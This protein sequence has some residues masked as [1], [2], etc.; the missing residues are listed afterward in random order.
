MPSL[1]GRALCRFVVVVV[2]LVV[3]PRVAA[4][5]LQSVGADRLAATF[6]NVP[7]AAGVLSLVESPL[8]GGA[9]NYLPD[10]ANYAFAGK[11][12]VNKGPDTGTN[13]HATVVGQFFFGNPT[14]L[15]TGAA[16]IH[17]YNASYWI[18]ADFLNYNTTSAPLVEVARVQ[19]HSWIATGAEVTAELV[20]EVDQRLDFAI[21]RDGFVAVAGVNNGN[22]TTL[23]PLLAQAYNHIT[24]GLTS[25]AHSAGFT[26]F[27]GAGRI[28][29]DLVAP[30]FLTSYATPK[31][32]TTA[33]V[34]AARAGASPHLLTGANLPR[35]VKALLLAGATKEEFPA[36]ARTTARPLDL[37]YGAGELNALL[38][39]RM[40][41][42]GRAAPSGGALVA[43]TGWAATS[44]AD[45]AQ[46]TYFFEVPADAA[47]APFSVALT[48]HRIVTD[49]SLAP[50]LWSP[51]PAV[52]ANFTL[53]L[54]VADGFT[55]GALL[56]ESASAVDNV[57]HIH[58]PALAPGRYALVVSAQAGT[59]TTDYA[60][61]W[62]A[63]PT[64]TVA[65]TVAEARESDGAP[66]EFTI[67]RAGSTATPLLVPLAVGGDAVAGTHYAAL[68]TSV[69][70]P[71]GAASATLSVTPVGDALAQGDRTV[72]VTVAG[73]YSLAAGAPASATVTVVDKPYDAW[74][75]AAFDAAQLTDEAVSGDEADPDADGLV[76]LLEYAL[77]GAPL[78]AADG[79]GI[80]PALG[81]ADGV[82]TGER[83][84]T[85]SY[86][87]PA[88]RDDLAYVVEWSADLT[89]AWQSGAGVAE[90]TARVPAEGGGGERVTVRSTATLAE[91]ARQFLRLRV[92]RP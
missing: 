6:A 78:D 35:V 53:R 85:L 51:S 59:A 60:L 45:G 10:A 88:G 63:T 83:H 30:D 66:G 91:Q 77:G 13:S 75:F 58:A 40:L 86:T 24:V 67:T 12:F 89:A 76:N 9:N 47:A 56:D 36:W 4:D 64:V 8:F 18:E 57:E 26:A 17:A 73:D 44:L 37:R 32:S 27:D 31:V 39:Y 23:P 7:T 3:L 71:A 22:S 49:G 72:T 68:P 43:E 50:F 25:G 38:S 81:L 16:E 87:Q 29:P 33:G 90:E 11:T 41:E 28:K 84:L 19:N 20:E 21:H 5:W 48:W 61:A 1:P 82:E 74:R 79:P 65:A 14:S 80:A 69:L 34:L 52:L 55:L 92:T 62:R 54:H 70:I 2:P 46:Q 15:L 42:S